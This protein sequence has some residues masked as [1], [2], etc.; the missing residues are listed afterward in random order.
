MVIPGRFNGPPTSGNGGYSAGLVASHVDGYLVGAR[1]RLHRPPPLDTELSVQHEDGV[2]VLHGDDVIATAQRD[3][4]GEVV[5]P[6]SHAEAVSASKA[7]YGFVEHPFP[8]CFVCGPER[9]DGLR[10]FPGRMPDGRTAAPFEVPEDVSPAMVWASLD[11]PSGW[12]V[13][14]ESRPYVLGEIAVRV[15]A[16]PEP[17][18]TCVV[19]AERTG[20]DGRKGFARSTLYS[21]TGAVLATARATWVALP[22]A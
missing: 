8:T 4:V 3:S 15:D 17:G 1:V 2:R 13:P 9:Q 22:T 16:L 20:E 7:Y 11:C 14:L 12:A 10:I 19:V 6:V 21:P 5:A 18:D